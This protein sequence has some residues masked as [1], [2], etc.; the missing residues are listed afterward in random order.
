MEI[1]FHNQ[2]EN[3]RDNYIDAEFTERG[4]GTIGDK[5]LTMAKDSKH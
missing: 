1:Q 5:A 3:S 2:K 4:S